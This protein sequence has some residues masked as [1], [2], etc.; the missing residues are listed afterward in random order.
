MFRNNGFSFSEQSVIREIYFLMDC[1][2]NKNY[3]VFLENSGKY[4]QSNNFRIRFLSLKILYKIEKKDKNINLINQF[5]KINDPYYRIRA[6]M[7]R[8]ITCLGIYYEE[9]NSNLYFNGDEHIIGEAMDK[10]GEIAQIT[11]TAANSSSEAIDKKAEIQHITT[12]LEM[13]NDANSKIKLEILKL[14]LRSKDLSAILQNLIFNKISHLANDKDYG[15]RLLFY[16]VLSK[17]N[18]LDE[19]TSIHLFDKENVGTYIYAIEDELP[20]IRKKALK[21]LKT[22]TNLSN[23]RVVAEFLVDALNDDS[24]VVRLCCL[25][26]FCF[27]LKKFKTAKYKMLDSNIKTI[28]F[29]LSEKNV[30]FKNLILKILKF[31]KIKNI[32]I[33]N[34]FVNSNLSN[35]EVTGCINYIIKKNSKIFLK[36]I[37]KYPYLI[38]KKED[39]IDSI[40]F[41]IDKLIQRYFLKS[42]KITF[43]SKIIKDIEDFDRCNEEHLDI[44]HLFN[45]IQSFS[46]PNSFLKDTDTGLEKYS[47]N[48]IHDYNDLFVGENS[49][50]SLENFLRN[51]IFNY[52]A[53]FY[54]LPYVF[55]FDLGLF[56]KILNAFKRNEIS[57]IDFILK[58]LK[59]IIRNP[60]F[61]TKKEYP[62]IIS[63]EIRTNEDLPFCF[64]IECLFEIQCNKIFI[65][66]V[67][68]NNNILEYNIKKKMK[69]VLDN[70]LQRIQY[71]IAVKLNSRYFKLSEFKSINCSR[72]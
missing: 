46:D 18:L 40:P 42:R 64:F 10:K 5:Y 15:V 63:R 66:L 48:K 1:L 6:L 71:C 60:R 23:L 67:D 61:S 56:C 70:D 3:A 49:H 36:A 55:N 38:S 59:I 32:N 45:E 9:V 11:L 39:K 72:W 17:L 24:E 14:I 69:I 35:L 53:L 31:V 44:L 62:I 19:K 26:I 7:I 51:A 27:L 4:L 12:I 50:P 13:I 29:S 28:F 41:L 16:S 65:L 47:S 34:L 58:L 54:L 22:T 30:K 43:T 21:S 33:L 8:R 68:G 25:R 2:H 20:V 37:L 52:F 57:K